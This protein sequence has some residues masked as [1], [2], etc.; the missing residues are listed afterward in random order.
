MKRFSALLLFTALCFVITGTAF[1][2]AQNLIQWGSS[3][4]SSDP[5][6]S[7]TLDAMDVG[8]PNASAD[9]ASLQADILDVNGNLQIT[10][11]NGYPGYQASV[12]TSI[13]NVS[14]APVK[15]TGI[16]V[17]P[18][19][20][21]DHIR[22]SLTNTEHGNLFTAGYPF[23]LDRGDSMD[24]RVVSRIRQIARQSEEYKFDIIIKAE[25]TSTG[26]GSNTDPDP[27]TGSNTGL[28]TGSNTDPNTGLNTDPALNPEPITLPDEPEVFEPMVVPSEPEASAFRELPFTGGNAPL[29]AFTGLTLGV[30]GILMRR[31]IKK[32]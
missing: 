32:Q 22:L 17:V 21:L 16:E 23:V 30:L 26:P 28:N 18:E 5:P 9:V 29:F 8:N 27:N 13:I 31:V 6:G 7:G 19:D 11:T 24:I 15:I 25:Q 20:G 14:G 4:I 10:I 1:A 2:E 3:A 12:D